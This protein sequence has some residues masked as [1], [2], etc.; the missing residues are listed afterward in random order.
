V[1]ATIHPGLIFL[2][3]TGSVGKSP[4]QAAVRRF[5]GSARARDGRGWADRRHLTSLSG[6]IGP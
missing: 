6:T 3:I 5:R 1:G 2:K 4:A